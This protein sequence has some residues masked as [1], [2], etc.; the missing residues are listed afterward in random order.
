MCAKSMNGTI[1]N[2]QFRE[3]LR[4]I[5]IAD[6]LRETHLRWFEHVQHKLAIAPLR[7]N[8]AMQVNGPPRGTGRQKRIWMEVEEYI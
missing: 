3:H 4:V 8:L 1:S 2:K 6:K 7:K 5:S